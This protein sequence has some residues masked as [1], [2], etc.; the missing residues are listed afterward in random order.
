MTEKA[1]TA[2]DLT[3]FFDGE[4]CQHAALCVRGLPGVFDTEARPWI[5]PANANAADV[6]SQVQLCPSGALRTEQAADRGDGQ[7]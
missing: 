4:V 1:Y 6:V 7:A 2:G 5:Q 3:V